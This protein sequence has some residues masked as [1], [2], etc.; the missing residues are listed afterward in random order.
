MLIGVCPYCSCKRFGLA[1]LDPEHQLCPE[2]GAGK[3]VVNNNHIPTEDH[4]LIIS[5]NPVIDTVNK[6]PAKIAHLY[7]N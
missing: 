1:L 3:M 4:K 2:C 7:H 6:P 5:V